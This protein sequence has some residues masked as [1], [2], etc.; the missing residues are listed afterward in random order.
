[1]RHVV[2]K[3]ASTIEGKAFDESSDIDALMQEAEG[4]LFE[5]ARMLSGT[6]LTNAAI[7]N[8]KELLG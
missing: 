3:V 1:M 5:V 8:A 7:E 2:V 6:T 4:K